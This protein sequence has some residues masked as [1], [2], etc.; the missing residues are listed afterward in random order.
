MM[1]RRPTCARS[2]GYLLLLVICAPIG[3]G[4]AG[5]ENL[6]YTNQGK[7]AIRRDTVTGSGMR[8]F[9]QNPQDSVNGIIRLT[10]VESLDLREVTV[11]VP[12]D[13][14]MPPFDKPRTLMVP[15][16]FTVSIQAHGLGH[17]RDLVLREDGT[18][19]YSE[20][21]SGE[22]VALSPDGTKTVIASGLDSPHGLD[23]YDGALY[24]TD[25]TRVF[26][27]NF[28]SP[29]AV[30]G[31][32]TLLTDRI[33]TGGLH[34]TRAVRV[35]PSDKQVYIS[36][37]STSDHSPEDDNS[38][39]VILRMKNEPG[40]FPATA[41]RGLRSTVGMDVHPETGE[42]WGA[43]NGT[44]D[45]SVDVPS[46]E[47]NILK[48][49]RHYGWPYS[50]SQNFTD[51]RY[52]PDSAKYAKVTGKVTPPV[53]ELQAH[54]EVLDLEFYPGTA[55]GA[56]WKN[57]MLLTCHGE[58]DFF[59]KPEG[60]R[61]LRVRANSDGTNARQADFVTGFKTDTGEIWGRP[62]GIVITGDGKTFFVS[63]DL[64][65]VIYRISKG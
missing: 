16:G 11:S 9:L 12:D 26:R 13:L 23:F 45:I 63:D 49:G 58:K 41:I 28:S 25:E 38:H 44:D 8:S 47:I 60:M 34:Y 53:A 61:I 6:F 48:I 3:I 20:I 40:E 62:V 29:T 59:V 22:V 30:T 4:C 56:D 36:V 7:Q 64:N 54:F 5:A 50:Y 33:P 10:P 52:R 17:P 35:L 39:A 18:I 27:F 32:S 21:L 2:L 24:Y 1:Q 37:G 15:P 43:D 14:N 55:L 65:G 42:L 57:A 46:E 51:V 31:S 19:F